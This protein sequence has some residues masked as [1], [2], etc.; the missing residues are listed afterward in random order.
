MPWRMIGLVLLLVL[1]AAF[2]TLNLSNRT[3]ISLGVHVFR[4]VPIFL[5]LLVAFLA[6]ILV[7]TPFTLGRGRRKRQVRR[8]GSDRPEKGEGKPPVEA[9]E[10]LEPPV[11]E[12]QTAAP[13]VPARAA[14]RGK[15]KSPGSRKTRPR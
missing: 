12:E 9:A 5:S 11:V 6:G 15:A 7:M 4:E 1:V 10:R 14:S 8:V 3:D 2:A 13:A